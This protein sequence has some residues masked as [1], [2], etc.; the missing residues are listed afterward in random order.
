MI[1]L[2]SE[3]K[4]EIEPLLKYYP[5]EKINNLLVYRNLAVYINYGKKAI[6]LAAN[7]ASIISKYDINVAMLFGFAG[8]LDKKSLDIGDFFIAE[9]IKLF[10]NGQPKYN[11]IMMNKIVNI[12]SCDLITLLDE[13]NFNNDYL[14]QFGDSVDME[15]FIF[16]K[17]MKSIGVFGLVMR[18]VS[19]LNDK[20]TIN[21][22]FEYNSHFLHSFVE[23][24]LYIDKDNLRFEIFKQTGFLDTSLVDG[25]KRSVQKRKLTFSERQYLYKKIKINS[26]QHTAKRS[27]TFNIFIEKGVDRQ[28]ID[29]NLS[30]FR[31][32]E[33]DDYVKYFHLLK[34]K[35][36]IIFANKKGEFLRKTPDNYTPNNESGYSILNA[37]NCIYDC[38][39]CFLKGYFKSFNPVIFLNYEDYFKAVLDIIKRDKRRP[40]YFY[41]GTFSDSLAMF[42]LTNFNKKLIEFFEGI[43]ENVFLELRTKST[44][45][46]W[47]LNRK[48]SKHIIAAFSVNPQSVI[49][50]YEYLAPP[51]IDRMNAVKRLLDKGH[52]AGIRIDP[53]FIDRLQEYEGLIDNINNIDGIHSVE[54]G[55]L[56]FDKNDYESM[57]KKEPSILKGLVFD[58]KMYRYKK[59]LRQKAIDFF[60]KRLNDFY[61]NMEFDG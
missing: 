8:S 22:K 49:D 36:A 13:V 16:A 17:S 34:D 25:I 59:E 50:K 20:H 7:I 47:L 3:H 46:D 19:D 32:Y 31:V 51:L 52:N 12:K 4:N 28:R 39:Y 57:L 38:S 61:M 58:D 48:P 29:I 23:K 60:K 15:S 26:L 41:A 35:K 56:R 33:I 1:L 55:F 54:I 45:I 30:R 44:N 43:D 53:V 6:T 40:L 24:L 37:F 21:E 18:V 27:S 11:P 10:C 2:A 14:L 9:K 42:Y 5:F